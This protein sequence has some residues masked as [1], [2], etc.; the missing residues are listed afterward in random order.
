MIEKILFCE[1]NRP[2]KVVQM[3]F[4]IYFIIKNIKTI[5]L[6]PCTRTF[7]ELHFKV[8]KK[9]GSGQGD[10]SLFTSLQPT[11]PVPIGS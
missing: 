7:R 11:M 4:I 10:L 2:K 6:K 5:K 9:P 8:F 1:F 3:P